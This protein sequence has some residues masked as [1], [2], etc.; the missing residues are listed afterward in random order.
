[1]SMDRGGLILNR[2]L[3]EGQRGQAAGE[4]VS[5]VVIKAKDT[6][7]EFGFVAIKRPNPMLSLVER[8]KKNNQIRREGEALKN[9]SHKV[10]SQYVESDDWPDTRD[11]YLITAWAEGHELEGRLRN[12]EADGAI[13]TMGETLEILIQLA[14]LLAHSHQRGVVHN[15]LDAKHLFWDTENAPARLTVIDWAN[16]ALESDEKPIAT[17]LDDLQQYGELMHRLLTGSTLAYAL[18][19][20]GDS[21]WRVELNE[22]D[23]PNDLQRILAR[24]LGRQGESV[25]EDTNLLYEDLCWFQQRQ[26]TPYQEQILR[27]DA[28]LDENSTTALDEAEGLIESIATWNPILV[29]EQRKRLYRLRR[30]RAENLARIGGKTSLLAEHWQVA[31]EEIVNTFGSD[32]QAMPQQEERYIYLLG[33]LMSYLEPDSQRYQLG[34]E[35]IDALFRVSAIDENEALDKLL[36][37]YGKDIPDQDLLIAALSEQT[38]RAY[39][40]RARIRQIVA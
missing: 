31:R 39:P 6:W 14:D 32:I 29:I 2:Y 17:R 5:G 19:L 18:R 8:R 21:N 35:V 37:L 34:R 13:L 38:D 11:Y 12:L 4:G 30:E 7:D 27:V 23:I 9:L 28:L 33:D 1:M 26:E 15:D 40:L 10:A 36:L 20:G 22:K 16:C 3:R 24:I 25:Y